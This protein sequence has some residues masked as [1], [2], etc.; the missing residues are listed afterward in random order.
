[1]NL[2]A[3]LRDALV[4][5]I[6]TAATEFIFLTDTT[7][8][9]A[10]GPLIVYMNQ[11]MLQAFGYAEAD[12]IGRNPAMFWG[13]QTDM[14]AVRE[15]RRSISEH[16]TSGGEYAAYD[17]N[18]SIIWVRFSGRILHIE[19]L[20]AHWIAIGS[21]ITQSRLQLRQIQELSEFR[22]DL[23]A[24][25][26]H[27]FGGP[28]TVVSGFAELLLEVGEGAVPSAERA[29]ILRTI[30]R[31]AQRL[32]NVAIDTLT[33]SRME[34]EHLTIRRQ[35]FDVVELLH[36]IVD[37][38]TDRGVIALHSPVTLSIN[39]DRLRIRQALDNLVGNA[40][41]YSPN[42]TPVVVDCR[43]DHGEVVIAVRDEGIGI[44]V[45]QLHSIFERYTRGSNARAKGIPGTGF[46]LYLAEAIVRHHGGRIEAESTLDAGSTFTLRLPCEAQVTPAA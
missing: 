10:G 33:V 3:A 23:I 41:K 21:D 38:Y 26:A 22:G 45:E 2:S 12:V 29:D 20:P 9:A 27:D 40:V 36:E 31:E 25:L 35:P 13:P 43:L 19:G 39:A 6:D 7:P 34:F 1:M 42:E 8:P 4:S 18:G 46:G 30:R 32:A 14:D 11:A 15:L 17:R 24:M 44:P 5:A 28:L 16:R 37:L